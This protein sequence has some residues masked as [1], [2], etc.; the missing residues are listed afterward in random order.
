M[1]PHPASDMD[2]RTCSVVVH[3]NMCLPQDCP[4]QASNLNI[5]KGP[6][7]PTHVIHDTL[8]GYHAILLMTT[9]SARHSEPVT[10]EK[11]EDLPLVSRFFR[12]IPPLQTLFFEARNTSLPLIRDFLYVVNHPWMVSFSDL[13]RCKCAI[14]P[15]PQ[16][17]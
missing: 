3:E 5:A 1:E 6:H 16:K 17:R 13:Y 14:L 9:G 10:S 8:S 12:A 15:S 2:T 7:E 4:A 11:V